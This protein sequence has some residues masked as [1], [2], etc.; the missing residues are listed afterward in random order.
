MSVFRRP[1]LPLIAP[2]R[3]GVSEGRLSQV[4]SSSCQS[5][6]VTVLVARSGLPPLQPASCS[7]SVS[8]RGAVGC[9]GP[10]A[11]SELP[12]LQ[13]SHGCSVPPRADAESHQS[14]KEP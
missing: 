5:W 6:S 10:V 8:W 13:R 2:T 11:R 7:G 1:L 3:H 14:V 12:P 9:I 4:E